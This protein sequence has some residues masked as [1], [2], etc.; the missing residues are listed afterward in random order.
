MNKSNI[1]IDTKPR[2]LLSKMYSILG[3]DVMTAVED[4][5]CN[6]LI[7][8]ENFIQSYNWMQNL[9]G[10]IFGTLQRKSWRSEII[11]RSD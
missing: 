7:G 2:S 9:P 5:L 11:P 10:F 8:G 1:E 3:H 6:H 4:I